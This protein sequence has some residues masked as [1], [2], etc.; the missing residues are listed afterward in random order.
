MRNLLNLK[1]KQIL[2]DEVYVQQVKKI[3]V[4][5]VQKNEQNMLLKF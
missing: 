4:L 2:I 3:I 5:Y 1:F